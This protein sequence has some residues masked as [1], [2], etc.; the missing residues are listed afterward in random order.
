METVKLTELKEGEHFKKGGEWPD[1][2]CQIIKPI[3]IEIDFYLWEAVDDR[4][5]FFTDI[6]KFPGDLIISKGIRFDLH[7]NLTFDIEGDLIVEGTIWQEKGW[8]LDRG[9]YLTVMGD[10][11]FKEGSKLIH[12]V[13]TVKFRHQDFFADRGDIQIDDL[14]GTIK[15][16]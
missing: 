11:I 5:D 15:F 1:T 14:R 13:D 4:F 9:G 3:N 12:S 7:G 2:W 16:I 10:V 6:E 8:F